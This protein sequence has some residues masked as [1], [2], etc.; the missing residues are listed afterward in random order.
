[1]GAQ[2]SSRKGHNMPR[3]AKSHLDFHHFLKSYTNLTK[4]SK[5]GN[6]NLR[7]ATGTIW[8]KT[9]I[10]TQ[11]FR[12]LKKSTFLYIIIEEARALKMA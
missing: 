3:P 2:I 6:Y 1:M 4:R 10:K 9:G 11:L 7:T 8:A 5:N 12:H